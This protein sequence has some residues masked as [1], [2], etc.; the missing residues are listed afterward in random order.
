LFHVE[1]SITDPESSIVI[2]RGVRAR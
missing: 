2:A 1:Q